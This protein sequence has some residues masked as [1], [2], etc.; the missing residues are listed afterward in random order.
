MHH[1]V[2][3]MR[4]TKEVAVVVDFKVAF[5]PLCRGWKRIEKK[6]YRGD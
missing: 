3:V 4:Q 6:S 5:L 2:I 1:A